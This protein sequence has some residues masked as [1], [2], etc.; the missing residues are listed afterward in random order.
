MRNFPVHWSEGLFLV[1]QHFQA[2]DRHW[3]ELLVH[4]EKFDHEYNY[5]L[6]WIELSHDA[7][8]NQS[9]QIQECEARTRE[10]TII[11]L[12]EGQ[13][14]DRLA[15]KEAL[16]K[17]QKTVLQA[18]LQMPFEQAALV[19]IYLAIPKW[20]STGGNV[21]VEDRREQLRFNEVRATRVDESTGENDQEVSLKSLSICLKTSEDA[22]LSN[23]EILPI[24]R[25]KRAGEKGPEV[26]ADYIPPV[27]TIDAWEPLQKDIVQRIY[28][29]IGNKIEVL[30]E[31]IISRGITLTSQDPGDLDR[32]LMLMTLNPAYA[33]LFN[34]AFARGVHPFT[35]YSELCRIVG[36]LSIFTPARRTVFARTLDP[37]KPEE[38]PLYDHD[39]LGPIF[40]RVMA[41]LRFL[42]DLVGPSPGYEQRY[43]I[44]TRLGMRVTI[45]PEWLES[46]W[47]WF[48]GVTFKNVTNDEVDEMLEAGRGAETTKLHW[49][50]GSEDKVDML[51]TSRLPGVKM[52]KLAQAP[53]ILPSGGNWVYYEIERDNPAWNDIQ[54][55]GT[56]AM[57]LQDRLIENKNELINQRTIIVN[58]QGRK[59]ELDF[60][61]FAVRT[62]T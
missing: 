47:K 27:L 60:A 38:I 18:N 21:S 28:D 32:L 51:F 19:M 41:H 14:P 34:L 2:A 25:V 30:S 43:F 50:L 59:A 20:R 26:D 49:K 39:N 13:E 29:W 61:L 35:A 7:I 33:S 22:D 15:M 31:Q 40:K 10:G 62:T 58:F 54:R 42:L 53:A 44:G 16:Q 45:K 1:P 4:S 57:R 12:G 3:N 37:N 56:L 24:A 11:A 46:S 52:R 8:L 5:G 6:R 55:T 23:Y 48:V 9:F 17:A 36:Q